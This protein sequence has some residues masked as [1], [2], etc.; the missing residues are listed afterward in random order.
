MYKTRPAHLALCWTQK[1]LC[2][3]EYCGLIGDKSEHVD[4]VWKLVAMPEVN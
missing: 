1:P 4:S 3:V 2:G